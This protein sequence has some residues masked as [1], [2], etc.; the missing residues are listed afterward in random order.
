MHYEEKVLT[1]TFPL[2]ASYKARTFRLV[3]GIY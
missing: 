2:Y 3:P 1:A